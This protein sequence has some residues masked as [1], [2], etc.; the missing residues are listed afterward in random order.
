MPQQRGSEPQP[1]Q[2]GEDGGYGGYGYGEGGHDPAPGAAHP[3]GE[4]PRY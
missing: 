3:Y 1:G 4:Q 2:Y